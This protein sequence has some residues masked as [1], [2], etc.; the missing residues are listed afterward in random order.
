MKHFKAIFSF[1]IYK[2]ETWKDTLLIVRLLKSTKME[3]ILWVF[4]MYLVIVK[5]V[6]VC[7][8]K[9][10]SWSQK[11]WVRVQDT[12]TLYNPENTQFLKNKWHK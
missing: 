3:N 9:P 10:S 1:H 11:A 12:Y 7:W 4:E 6:E 8:Q 5:N 2:E